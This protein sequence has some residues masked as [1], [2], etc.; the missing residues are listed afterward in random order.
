MTET[1]NWGSHRTDDPLSPWPL[2]DAATPIPTYCPDCG[3]VTS[4]RRWLTVGKD[5]AYIYVACDG[6]WPTWVRRLGSLG[7]EVGHWYLTLGMTH[8]TGSYDPLTGEPT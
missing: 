8:L 1:V 6:G 4:I 3:R 2:R 5:S 7:T